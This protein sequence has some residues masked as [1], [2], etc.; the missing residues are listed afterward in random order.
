MFLLGGD[1]LR[2]NNGAARFITD[3]GDQS[4]LAS[5][6]DFQAQFPRLVT[7]RRPILVIALTFRA[8]ELQ[9]IQ[10]RHPSGELTTYTDTHDQPAYVTY[11]FSPSN[12]VI[13]PS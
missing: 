6:D 9:R 3:G 8:A 10:Q 1:A 7:R 13:Q 5:A 2:V 4:D 11:E 12:E